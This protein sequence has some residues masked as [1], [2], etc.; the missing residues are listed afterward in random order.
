MVNQWLNNAQ[1][2]ID[3][4]QADVSDPFKPAYHIS[5]KSGLLNDPNGL[6]QF[7]NQYHIFY[8]WNPFACDH[9]QKFWGHYISD[10]LVHWREVSPAL[11]PDRP[12]DASGCYSGSAFV[13]NDELY[14]FYTGNLKHGDNQQLRTSSQCLAK[15]KNGI[16]FEKVGIVIDGQPEGYTAHFRD[17]K[18]WRSGSVWYAVLGGQTDSLQGQV[19]LY[20]SKN[21]TEWQFLGPVAGSHIE[22]FGEFGYMWECP[23]MFRLNQ[24]WVMLASPQGLAPLGMKY[25]N[26]YQSGYLT[27]SLDAEKAHFLASHFEELDRGFEFYAPQTFEDKQGRR[28]MLAWMGLPEENDHPSIAYGWL[29]QMTLPRE[30]TLRGNKLYQMPVTELTALRQSH[31]HHQNIWLNGEISFPGVAGECYELRTVLS[32]IQACV[33]LKLRSDGKQQY[34]LLHIDPINKIVTLDR[35]HSGSG[36]GGV[37]QCQLDELTSLE[38][39]IYMD[40]SSVEIFINQGAEAFSA[41][42]FPDSEATGISFMSES[43]CHL[44]SLDYFSLKDDGIIK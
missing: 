2:V 14:L 4:Y 41:R 33:S 32:N 8:Q 16:D 1:E 10:D 29:H 40:R 22:P 35:N 38:L 30:L 39:V 13:H 23:D 5:P 28:I 31:I 11:A 43:P 17:P 19:L 37:R 36:Y 21:L 44:S 15:S 42:I 9:S 26:I 25:Q 18:I 24:T 34:T 7:N 3:G 27:G 20:R 6:I 12:Y